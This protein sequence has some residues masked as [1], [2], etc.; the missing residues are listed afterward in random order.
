VFLSLGREEAR[1][2]L[3]KEISKDKLAYFLPLVRKHLEINRE[4]KDREI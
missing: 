4:S 2:L 3:N 1:R